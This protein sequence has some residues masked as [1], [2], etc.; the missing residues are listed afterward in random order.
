MKKRALSS[1][2][3]SSSS[4]SSSKSSFVADYTSLIPS[5]RRTFLETVLGG[6]RNLKH[7]SRE[8]KRRKWIVQRLRR[9]RLIRRKYYVTDEDVLTVLLVAFTIA[10]VLVLLLCVRALVSFF[11]HHRNV[12]VLKENEEE[13][14]ETIKRDYSRSVT[15][16]PEE[17]DSFTVDDFTPNEKRKKDKKGQNAGDANAT[18][19]K[20]PLVK[21]VSIDETFGAETGPEKTKKAKRTEI[22]AKEQ[23]MAAS[24]ALS[25]Q[26]LIT[27]E[28]RTRIAEL[29]Q[30]V[31]E[32]K[33]ELLSTDAL[34][35][36]C[37]DAQLARNLRARK[38]DV[39]KA[40][41]MLKKTLL[42]RKEYKPEL[43]TFEDI[44][45]ELKT[46]KQYR[47]GRDRS[48]RRIIVMRPS[49]ENTRE[50]DGNIR[51]LVYTFENALWRT[52]GERIVRGSSNIP[53]L[54]QEQICVLIN[55]TKWS[56]KL[57]P[58]WR[59]SM[60]TLHIMQEHYPERLGLAVCYD[61]PSV[62]S[63]FWK[64]IS[65]FIDVK[66]KSK[67]RFV[68]P[69]GDKQK[70]AKKMNATFHP[71]TIDSDMGGRVD[72]TWDLDEYKV[73]LQRYDAVKKNVFETLRERRI[74]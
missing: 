21:R 60:E 24:N 40:F 61:P 65:P 30:L 62:F 7:I 50:H 69:R 35:M 32:E 66:T 4:S 15:M 68:Q 10:L 27:V 73:F 33:K 63:I 12:V 6:K 44:E 38:W 23:P 64:L 16:N 54:A 45:E 2:F 19:E 43:I 28:E 20:S 58:P 51:L 8:I 25:Q 18:S 37:S 47:S 55:F 11:K 52:N 56:L 36:Y 57:S 39:L 42:W 14:K 29:R 49:R 53:A 26:S 13:T 1:I 72:A 70:A 17:E 9:S 74:E 46:G 67:I 71:N 48:G 41:E 22:V 34:K 59:T 5:L 31:N 3:S